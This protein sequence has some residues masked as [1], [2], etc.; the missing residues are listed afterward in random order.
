MRP[1]FFHEA[2][3]GFV[4]GAIRAEGT[5]KDFQYFVFKN[6]QEAAEFAADYYKL[7]QEPPHWDRRTF[8]PLVN[9]RSTETQRPVGHYFS[10]VEEY[11][12]RKLFEAVFISNV[13]YL[14]MKVIMFDSMVTPERIKQV[15]ISVEKGA[16]SH[17]KEFE[18]NLVNENKY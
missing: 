14:S 16:T 17:L 8:G 4:V 12:E 11:A 5:Y 15:E 9:R 1:P 10:T 2:I 18:G 6:I 13:D 3:N 7:Q